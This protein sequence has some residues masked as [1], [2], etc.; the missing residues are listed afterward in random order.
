M[1]KSS[2][3][4]WPFSSS[5]KVKYRVMGTISV[6]VVPLGRMAW[7]RICREPIFAV[8]DFQVVDRIRDIT[9]INYLISVYLL[10]FALPIQ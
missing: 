3:Y 1:G 6:W 8:C 10:R 4:F 2:N 5:Q 9:I 7:E